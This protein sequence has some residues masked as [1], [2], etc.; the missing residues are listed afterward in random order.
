MTSE[1]VLDFNELFDKYMASNQKVWVH[2]RSKTL[3]ASEVFGCIRKAFFDKRGKEFGY[4]PDEEYEEDWGALERGNLI[5]N[6][7]VVPAVRDHMPE[8]VSVLFSGDDQLTLVLGRNSATPD[9]LITGLPEGCAVRIKGGGQDIF[10]PNIISDCIILEIKS[11][12]PRATLLEERAKHHG[13]TQVQMGLFHA[14]T[15]FKPYFGIV[16]YIDASF[17]SRLT[18]FVIEYDPKVFA[19]AQSRAEAVWEG[20]HPNEY[21]AEGRFSNA[22]DHCK[23]QGACGTTNRDSIPSHAD[24]ERQVTPETLEKIDP[25]VKKFFEAKKSKEEAERTFELAG[26]EIKNFLSGTNRRKMTGPTWSV[27]WFGQDGKSR[28]DTKAME[29]DGIDLEKYKKDGNPFDVL[30]VTPKLEKTEK[31]PRRKK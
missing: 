19:A 24:S 14:Q 27:T 3:G 1:I 15:E 8:N 12:D 26:E 6:Y 31:A 23:W 18:P 2:D 21:L 16:L 13:Q 17:L 29:A 22:C 5:E 10:I 4:S 20:T 11:I 9:G 30:R 25:L 7:F 28:L